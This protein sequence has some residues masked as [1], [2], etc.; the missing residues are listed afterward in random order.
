LIVGIWISVPA[1]RIPY[2]GWKRWHV[3]LGLIFGLITCTWAFSG[4]LSMDP[5]GWDSGADLRAE[6]AALRGATWHTGAYAMLA[7]TQALAKAQA[8][9]LPPI[10]ELELTFF[11]REAIYIAHS[12]ADSL[13]VP[14]YGAPFKLF[15]S[16]E[17]ASMMAQAAHG[18]F[19]EG[20]EVLEYES[21]YIDRHH[22]LPL[23]AMAVQLND[24][25]QTLFY[26]DLKTARIVKSYVKIS[27]WNRWL[28]HGL[29]SMDLPWLYRN[30]P[31]WDILVLALLAGGAALSITSLQLAWR[32]LRTLL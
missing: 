4:M 30:R 23:P 31:A 14:D 18:T 9:G 27:R 25:E 19:M 11:E 8:A 17:I 7:P 20:R 26:I 28:Y 1:G 12:D 10:K 29:H 16:P 13:I 32:Y 5:F 6:A 15:D 22:R 21:Y 2:K 24:P 3:M